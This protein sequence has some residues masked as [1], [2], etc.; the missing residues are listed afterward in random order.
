MKSSQDKVSGNPNLV[1]LPSY[2]RVIKGTSERQNEIKY[3]MIL[4]FNEMRNTD[5]EKKTNEI[6]DIEWIKPTKDSTASSW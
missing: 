5:N 2:K 1:K 6:T 4:R 3:L